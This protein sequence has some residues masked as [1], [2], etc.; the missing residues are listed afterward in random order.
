MDGPL[1]VYLCAILASHFTVVSNLLIP[2]CFLLFMFMIRL[3]EKPD[4]WYGGASKG[5]AQILY[6]RVSHMCG[7]CL[8]GTPTVHSCGKRLPQNSLLIHLS[9]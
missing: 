3:E 4:G 1:H 2:L 5:S 9:V 7:M 8:L 6:C